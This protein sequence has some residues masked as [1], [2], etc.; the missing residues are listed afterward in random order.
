[1]HTRADRVTTG[2]GVGHRIAGETGGHDGEPTTSTQ[3]ETQKSHCAHEA[4]YL[5]QHRQSEPP[6]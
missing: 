6:E 5:S 1:M 2:Q 3:H 4:K